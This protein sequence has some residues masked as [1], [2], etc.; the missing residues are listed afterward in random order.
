[1]SAIQARGYVIKGEGE[2]RSRKVEQYI[3]ENDGIRQENTTEKSGATKGKLLPTPSGELVSDFLVANFQNIVDYDFTAGVENQLDLIAQ[4]KLGR[5]EMLRAFYGPFQEEV[6]AAEDSERFN[7]AREL[8]IDPKSGRPIFAKIGRHGGYLQVGVNSG[9]STGGRASASDKD[10]NGKASTS[11]KNA[12]GRSAP[13]DKPDFYSLPA[14]TTVKTVTLEQA[15]QQMALPQLP[16]TLGTLDDGTP[17][18]VAA[19]PFGPY[20]KGGL[21]SA[22]LKVTG[23]VIKKAEELHAPGEYQMGATFD[24][25]TI[26]FATALPFYRAKVDAIVHDWGD[27]QVVLGAY[28]PYVKGPGRYN[29]VKIPEGTDPQQ[30]TREEAEKM[31]ADKPKTRRRAP[32]RRAAKRATTAKGSATKSTNKRSTA[33]STT[34]KRQQACHRWA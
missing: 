18:I 30:L 28:G 21:Y 20:V 11:G 19:G 16:R 7:G 24:P 5:V 9:K 6:R 15:L 34:T 29:N 31:L 2:G 32:R 22:P 12:S 8:G 4:H 1:M 33:K 27:I 25:Y 23:A 10:T 26:D 3:L 17:L 14:G 13:H